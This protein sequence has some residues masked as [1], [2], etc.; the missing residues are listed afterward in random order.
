M[1][2]NKKTETKERFFNIIEDGGTGTILLYGDISEWKEDVS[3]AKIFSELKEAEGKYEE[4]SI[5]VNSYGGEVYAGIAIFN[6]LR[7]S[8]AK[9]TIYIDGIAASMAS[10]IALCGKPVYMSKYARLMLHGVS[11]GSWGTRKNLEKTIEEMEVLEDTLAKMYATKTGRDVDEIKETYFDGS[12]HWLTAQEAL[13]YGFIDGI[14]DAEPLL[15]SNPTNDDI[16]ETFINRLIEPQNKK[17]MNL[18]ELKKRALFKDAAT[19]EDVLK[20]VAQLE[21]EAAKV[22]NLTNK[23]SSLEDSLKVFEDKA[24]EAEEAEMKALLDA[25]EKDGRIDAKTRPTFEAL[26][27]S[28]RVN[29]EAAL[30]ALPEKK[31]VMKNL[32][33]NDE[34]GPWNKRMQEIKN[35]LKKKV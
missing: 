33:G 28:D 11:G 26:L 15:T 12:D 19:D 9:I 7:N 29:G 35:N 34:D 6:A 17:N 31:Y 21:S 5:R 10:V 3:P 2:K 4:I 16:Y 1:R 18:E 22:P 27:R 20:I 25:A 8:Q 14:Y 32:G 30:K 13:D 24:K 23:V